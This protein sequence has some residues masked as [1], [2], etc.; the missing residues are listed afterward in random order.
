MTPPYWLTEEECL[1]LHDLMMAQYGGSCGVRD[2]GL[3]RSALARPQQLLAY[4]TPTMPELATAYAA[5]I[6]Q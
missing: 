3:L 6:C 2:I 1:A 5:G 4:G